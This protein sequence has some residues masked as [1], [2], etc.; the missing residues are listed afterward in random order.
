VW[1]NTQVKIIHIIVFVIIKCIKNQQ[2]ALNF[3]AVFLLLYFHPHVSA[4]NPA[5]FRVTFL[6]QEYSV[7]KCVK[8]L[9]NIGILDQ[10][11]SVIDNLLAITNGL[12]VRDISIRVL[13]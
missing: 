8:L 6:L 2:N 12:Y 7:T 5:I 13:L 9:H 4:G 11:D 10:Y 3:T 1:G